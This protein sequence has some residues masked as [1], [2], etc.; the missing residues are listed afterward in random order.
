MG[1]VDSS[2]EKVGNDRLLLEQL[3]LLQGLLL[4]SQGNVTRLMEEKTTLTECVK[5]LETENQALRDRCEEATT[6]CEDMAK[7][8][9]ERRKINNERH[10]IELGNMKFKLDEAQE[11]LEAALAREK[12]AKS[13]AA[14]HQGQI[15]KTQNALRDEQGVSRVI[16]NKQ[17]SFLTSQYDDL[18]TTYVACVAQNLTADQIKDIFSMDIRT[19]WK[20]PG[21]HEKDLETYVKKSQFISTVFRG[22]PR[23]QR[24]VGEFWALPFI[25]V[26]TKGDKEKQPLLA[27]FCADW[28]TTHLTLDA[29]SMELMQSIGVNDIPAY[30]TAILPLLPTVRHLDISGTNLSTLQWVCCLQSRPFVLEVR[31]CGGITDFSPLLKPPGLER[32]VYNGLTN[33]AIEKITEELRGKGVELVKY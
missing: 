16:I 14:F 24:V 23:L 18:K 30:L 28:S 10:K 8:A 22:L 25:Y 13:L 32:V 4:E 15:E 6:E 12:E 11:A 9:E 3:V 29:A 27:G 5:E 2:V 7:E 20:L 21:Y 31:G 1:D 33:T 26:N 19:E 17:F